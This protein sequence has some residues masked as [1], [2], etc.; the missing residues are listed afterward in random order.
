[1]NGVCDRA[2]NGGRE[3][4]SRGDDKM[5]RS[6]AV[7]F[8]FENMVLLNKLLSHKEGIIP[9]QSFL[10]VVVVFDCWCAQEGY[11]FLK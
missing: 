5:I 8:C 1:M 3:E 2:V 9:N 4:T 7:L 6:F 11:C 10:V